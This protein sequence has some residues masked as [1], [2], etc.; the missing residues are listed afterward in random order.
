MTLSLRLLD[1]RSN[2]EDETG[3]KEAAHYRGLS[4][5]NTQGEGRYGLG[6]P[7]GSPARP[8]ALFT[9]IGLICYPQ[10][11]NMPKRVLLLRADAQARLQ[12]GLR[13]SS[14]R[15]LRKYRMVGNAGNSTREYGVFHWGLALSI[16]GKE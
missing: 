14:Q 7:T 10:L 12:Q 15:Q 2:V 16:P 3:F 1:F 6:L 9:C 4:W 13:S 8:L 5:V 11:L